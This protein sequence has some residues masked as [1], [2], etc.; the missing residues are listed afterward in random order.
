MAVETKGNYEM[1]IGLEIHAE[2]LTR[3][4]AFC[5]CSTAFGE[6]PNTQVCPVCLGLP[7]S[8]PVLNEEAVNLAALAGLAL[9]CQIAPVS[10]FDRKHYFYPDLPKAY[11]TTQNE[12][13]IAVDGKVEFDFN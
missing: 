12:A 10:R 6:A 4:K 3:S 2:L 9:N 5:A 1:V 7:G 8:L 11:Q 13:P